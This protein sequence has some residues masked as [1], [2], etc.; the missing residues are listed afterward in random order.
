MRILSVD[1]GDSRIGLGICDELEM[2]ASPL[3][4]I[5]S[6]SM[7]KNVDKVAAIAINERVE[8]IVVGLPLNMD[9][10]EGERASKARSFGKVLQRVSGIDVDYQDERLTSVA[11]EEIMDTVGVKKTKRKNIVDSIAAQLILEGYLS[12][13][14]NKE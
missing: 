11:A 10:T 14:K 1:Y 13:R 12:A 2:L 3:Y 7:R 8:K 6:D 5:K 4:T 9:G